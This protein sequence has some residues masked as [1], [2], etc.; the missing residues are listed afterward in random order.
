MNLGQEGTPPATLPEV[1]D[2]KDLRRWITR[3]FQPWHVSIQ[4]TLPK[5]QCAQRHP[6]H[7]ASCFFSKSALS[8]SQLWSILWLQSF[9]ASPSGFWSRRDNP[10]KLLLLCTGKD[11]EEILSSHGEKPRA[12]PTMTWLFKK[13]YN[14]CRRIPEDPEALMKFQKCD[15]IQVQCE[16]AQNLTLQTSQFFWSSYIVSFFWKLFQ[17]LGKRC[18]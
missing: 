14:M 7:C 18:L 8:S 1:F 11:W 13:I 12:S 4:D 6:S 2:S 17:W 9:N 15:A 5:N 10:L 16:S 3:Y